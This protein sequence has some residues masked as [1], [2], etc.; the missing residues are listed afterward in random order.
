MG[1]LIAGVVVLSI[2]VFVLMWRFFINEFKISY[3]ETKLENRGVDISA[4]KNAGL[5]D[6]IK[7]TW[8]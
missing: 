4:V 7:M 8:L 1:S 3:Y 5:I 2:L 6:I